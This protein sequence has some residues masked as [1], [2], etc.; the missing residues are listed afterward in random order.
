MLLLV[1]RGDNSTRVGAACIG[2]SLGGPLSQLIKCWFADQ[3]VP[4]LISMGGGNL[5]NCK[6]DSIDLI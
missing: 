5:F 4:S 3:M 6:L 2:S 1:R